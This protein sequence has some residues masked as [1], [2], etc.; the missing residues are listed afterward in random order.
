M[1]EWKRRSDGSAI[2]LG[3]P[4]T[5]CQTVIPIFYK[6]AHCWGRRNI[7]DPL[8]SGRW[9]TCG[10]PLWMV[11]QHSDYVVEK[12]TRPWKI[13][14][15]TL[16][17]ENLPPIAETFVRDPQGRQV[18]EVL[19]ILYSLDNSS[20]APDVLVE[21]ILDNPNTFAYQGKHTQHVEGI[22][23]ARQ[24]FSKLATLR[25]LLK[26]HPK[27]DRVPMY[28]G[29]SVTPARLEDQELNDLLKETQ[30]LSRMYPK[31]YMIL[32]Q[33]ACVEW[34]DQEENC[35]YLFDDEDLGKAVEAA[36]TFR[37]EKQ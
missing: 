21:K 2:V 14:I 10:G 33:S 36:L 4:G 29:D 30:T 34:P 24:L 19:G 7:G 13:A 28:R 6:E 27:L 12:L 15:K 1:I 35:M 26:A 22:Q 31:D 17:K 11:P 37:R 5:P 20:I 8:L 25:D 32:M 16:L 9:I 3:T 23:A 18:A